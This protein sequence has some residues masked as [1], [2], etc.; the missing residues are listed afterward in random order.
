[1]IRSKMWEPLEWP[2]QSGLPSLAQAL[3]DHGQLRESV[4]EVHAL[5]EKDK[6][7]RLY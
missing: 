6:A 3:V 1:M 2:D 7:M 5:I 4:D